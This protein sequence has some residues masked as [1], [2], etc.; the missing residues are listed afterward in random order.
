MTL[1]LEL[2]KKYLNRRGEVV[3]IVYDRGG[4]S[5]HHWE[6]QNGDTYTDSGAYFNGVTDIRDLI[7][8]YRKIST[9]PVE[10]T[11]KVPHKHGTDVPNSLGTKVPHLHAD[12]IIAWAS[13]ET[14]EYLDEEDGEF[15]FTGKPIW[16]VDTVYR[17]KP[18]KIIQTVSAWVSNET[19]QVHVANPN[20]I[21]TFEDGKLIKAEVL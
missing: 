17:I 11:A 21:L 5:T 19:A 13:G 14:I 18:E 8:E 7:S 20:L 3:E 10:N 1:Q 9:S 15:Y 16:D 4:S 2:G 6:S 12:L